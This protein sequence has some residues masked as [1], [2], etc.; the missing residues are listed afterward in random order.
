MEHVRQLLELIF[1]FHSLQETDLKSLRSRN[2]FTFMQ[3]QL[4]TLVIALIP[5]LASCVNKPLN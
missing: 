1:N 3:Q 2:T 4:R 5:I